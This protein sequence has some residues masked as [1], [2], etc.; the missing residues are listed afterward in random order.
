MGLGVK[1]IGEG[2]ATGSISLI[3]PFFC[4][5]SVIAIG[6][7]GEAFILL[8]ETFTFRVGII[9]GKD[10]G[11]PSATWPLLSIL[12]VTFTFHAGILACKQE[13]DEEPW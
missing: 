10:D 8:M 11:T 6:G 4:S 9:A 3:V 7:G 2:V 12:M 5:R 13:D 1:N